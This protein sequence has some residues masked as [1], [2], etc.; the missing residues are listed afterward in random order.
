MMHMTV[1]GI[2][3]SCDETSAAVV[4]DQAILSNII[5]TQTI[6]QNY[7]GVVPEFAS[8]AHLKQLVPIINMALAEAE[9]SLC[10]LDGIAVTHGPGLAGSLLVGLGVA[11]GLALSLNIPFIG[12][13]HIEGHIVAGAGESP[14]IDHPYIAMVA[15]GGHSLLIFVEKPCSYKIIGQTIDDAAGEAFDKVAKVLELGYP[16]GPLIEKKAREGNDQAV[17]FPRA[18]LDKNNLDFSFSGL[19]TSVLYYVQ[20]KKRR[21]ETFSVA[22]VAASFQKAVVDVLVEKSFRALGLYG[23]KQLVLAGGVIRNS[24][25]RAEFESRCAREQIVLR[26]P[27]P[28]LCTDNAGMIARAGHFRLQRGERSDFGLDV[29][30]NLSIERDLA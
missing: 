21:A 1:L 27:D 5:R 10:D 13:N 24:A 11:K 17:N 23:C 20:N 16:G 6:H 4:N 18:L 22:D 3:T 14:A 30:P 12:V 25:L 7:G 9:L 29:H 2:E 26:I 8:R 28:V 15:S 19:K